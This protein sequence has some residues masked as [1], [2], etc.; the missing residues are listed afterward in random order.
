[1]NH[2]T[3]FDTLTFAWKLSESS[4]NLDMTEFG[5]GSTEPLELPL[6]TGMLHVYYWL[7]KSAS[8]YSYK[9]GMNGFM[10]GSLN[11]LNP[12]IFRKW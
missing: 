8:S 10:N 3:D 6:L 9:L 11:Y 1:M 5:V 12:L 2:F 4:T 7:Q